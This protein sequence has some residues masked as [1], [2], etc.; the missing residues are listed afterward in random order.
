M[1]G[2]FWRRLRSSWGRLDG[3]DRLTGLVLIALVVV[4]ILTFRDYAISNDEVVQHRYGEMIIAYYA[5]DLKDLRLFHF[6]N[7]YL[8]GGLF[9]MIAVLLAHLLPFEPYAIRHILCALI[10]IGGIAATAATARLIAG[11][12]AG[13]VAAL[14][15]AISGVWYGGMFN[16]TKD[17]PFGAAM[18]ASAF[19]L[20]RAMRDLPRPRWIDIIGF[21]AALGAALGLRALALFGVGY[22]GIAVLMQ[23][24]QADAGGRTR[25]LLQSTVRLLPAF[26]LAYAIMIASWPWASLAP[27]NPLRAIFAFT[28]FHYDIRTILAGKVYTMATIPRWY[29][30]VYLAI[31][32]PPVV[33]VGALAALLVAAWPSRTTG[34]SEAGEERSRL[35][36][37]TLFVAFMAVFPPLCEVLAHGPAF[38]GMRHFLFVLPVLAALAGV[39]FEHMLGALERRGRVL[40]AAGGTA[41]AAAIAWN[42]VLLVRLHPDQ[43]LYYSPVVGGLQGAAQRYDTD[44]WVNIMPEA[45]HSLES[46]LDRTEGAAHGTPKRRYTVGVC[47]ERLAFEKTADGRLQWTD[48]WREADF[49]IAPTHMHCDRVVQG[50]TIATIERL[51]VPIGVVKDRRSLVRPDIARDRRRSAVPHKGS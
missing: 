1:P 29:V 16:H 11:P 12:R 51:G 40:G 24:P 14:A 25:F 17:V 48:G 42:A 37:E 27:F 50:K 38:S 41:L 32:I 19:F 3:C 2:T 4:A 15:L 33:W 45:V 34:P 23:M 46:Y 44:Y 43:Y 26:V 22:A 28:H 6:D 30:P 39:G 49:F 21:G 18:I 35:R 10:G 31:K 36:R 20:L 8:Y 13:L 5:S 9:D 47:G 7:L